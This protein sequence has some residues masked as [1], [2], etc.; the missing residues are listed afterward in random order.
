MSSF[1]FFNTHVVEMK[2]FQYLLL[3]I[4]WHD[5]VPA[6]QSH[7]VY[8]CQVTLIRPVWSYVN[9]QLISC[10]WPICIY[11]TFRCWRCS[12]CAIACCTCNMDMHFGMSV[13]LCMASTLM[14]MSQ[15]GSYLPSWWL[16]HDSQ[17]AINISGPGL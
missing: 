9:V 12:S 6:L 16:Y 5:Y 7:T 3:Y 17:S 8:D 4:L 13:A 10:V 1:V 14:S 15:I 11:N 2:L